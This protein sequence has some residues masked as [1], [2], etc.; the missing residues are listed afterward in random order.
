MKPVRRR[1]KIISADVLKVTT[2]MNPHVKT[3]MNVPM[4]CLTSAVNLQTVRTRLEAIAA[5][6]GN[7]TQGTDLN[8][9]QILSR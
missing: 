3:L 6:A 9:L 2:G 8:A 1:V 4:N 5:H 7:I